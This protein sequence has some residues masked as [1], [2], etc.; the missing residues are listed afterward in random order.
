MKA[1]F[2]KQDRIKALRA[3][4]LQKP[5]IERE[6][7]YSSVKES[8]KK[9]LSLLGI[10]SLSKMIFCE[11]ESYLQEI[12]CEVL[13]ERLV[14]YVGPISLDYL[15]AIMEIFPVSSIWLLASEAKFLLIKEKAAKKLEQILDQY[16]Y[17]EKDKNVKEKRKEHERN[18]K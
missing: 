1:V 12:E 9:E 15:D 4:A 11:T 8:I 17:E 2:I 16:G 3:M 14:D 10:F 13:G 7:L 6:A 18:K 5:L